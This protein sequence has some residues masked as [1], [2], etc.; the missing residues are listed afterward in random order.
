VWGLLRGVAITVCIP[1]IASLAA[2]W[3]WWVELLVH[4]RAYYVVLL[5][6]LGIVFLV[7]RR[8]MFAVLC[9]SIGLFSA[10]DIAPLYFPASQP[11]AEGTTL[12]V[13]TAN[14][15]NRNRDHEALL[16]IIRR[17][18]PDLIVLH[19]TSARWVK[20]LKRLGDYP[21]RFEYP[22]SD[23]RGMTLLSRIPLETVQRIQLGDLKTS[24][25]A[26][27]SLG[28]S[29]LTVIGTHP[30]S[31]RSAEYTARRD[32]LL[33]D[34]GEEALAEARPL[35]VLA[36]LN[37]TPWSR[38]LQDILETGQIRDARRGFGIQPTWV[39]RGGLIQI[40]IDY[41][42]VSTDVKV[43]DHRVSGNFGSDHRAVIV[44]LKLR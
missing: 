22:R 44:D 39:R 4:F 11:V 12:R 40:P 25:R 6:P 29:P 35:L 8:W 15:R 26:T 17:E 37:T 16:A 36:D 2:R 19:E 10:A 31:P 33:H 3:S 1:A 42:L 43:L 28:G 30:V 14:V 5:V 38:Q 21:H 9:L 27:L 24:L 34:L 32:R 20:A 23:G 7:G 18:Q 41:V 13:M